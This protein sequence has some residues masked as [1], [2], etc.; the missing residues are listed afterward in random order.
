MIKHVLAIKVK[1]GESATDMRDMLMSM[2][3]K[4]DVIRDI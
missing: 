3:D 4:V 1:E 2:K